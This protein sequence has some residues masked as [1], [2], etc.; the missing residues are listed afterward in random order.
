LKKIILTILLLISLSVTS[1]GIE[2]DVDYDGEFVKIYGSSDYKNIPLSIRIYDDSRTYYFNQITSDSNGR[3]NDVL[4][5]DKNKEYNGSINIGGEIKAFRISTKQGDIVIPPHQGKVTVSVKGLEGKTILPR[6]EVII[7]KGDTALDVTKRA[8]R[9]KGIEFETRAGGYMKS[10]DGLGEF[11]YGPKSGWMYEI[12]GKFPDI[13]SDDV[14]VKDGDEIIWRYTLNLGEDIGNIYQGLPGEISII[15]D[16]AEEIL[17]NEKASR[18][19]LE[20]VLDSLIEVFKDIESKA[21]SNRAKKVIGDLVYRIID[22]ISTE[23]VDNKGM[24][25]SENKVIVSF[26]S[27]IVK[28]AEDLV[29]TVNR[30]N[31]IFK[32][33][34]IDREEIGKKLTIRIPEANRQEA[35]IA[36]SQ[37]VIGSIFQKGV[38]G[39]M[40][41]TEYG[42]LLLEGDTLRDEFFKKDIKLNLREINREN[43]GISGLDSINGKI[44]GIDI[45]VQGQRITN[46]NRAVKVYLPLPEDEDLEYQTV[47]LIREDGIQEILGGMYTGDG[48]ISFRTNI[49]NIFYVKPSVKDFSDIED[50]DWAEEEIRIMAGKGYINGRGDGI[51]DP[52]NLITRAEF[53]SIIT[54]ILKYEAKGDSL[55]FKDVGEDK[56]Y[57]KSVMAAYEKGIINGKSE[58][59]FNPDGYI[60][61]E[62]VAKIIENILKQEGFIIETS[63]ELSF[64]D[65]DD[66]SPWAKESVSLTTKLGITLGSDGKFLPRSNAT[67]AQGA[68]MLYRLYK[69]L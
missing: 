57:Y 2:V 28:K 5:L 44:I 18:E 52:H 67:R 47:F 53:V 35:E 68:V 20:E 60:T 64:T 10:I 3:F 51:F 65:K 24:K 50:L 17:E 59:T 34:H 23:E 49:L 55:P 54:R 13:S 36:F 29:D 39:I 40:I 7:E 43:L 27:D 56:W 25:I 61:R 69:L 4:T 63:G 1:Y 45:N 6:T 42:D 16:R 9:E 22:I 66:I 38:V 31:K 37:G 48:K 41:K 14:L 46:L 11:Q 15:L 26:G 12:N 8:L 62:E 58:E 21:D 32:D 19:E 33:Y 30:F